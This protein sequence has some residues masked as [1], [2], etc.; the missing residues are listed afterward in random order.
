[1]PRIK[2]KAEKIAFAILGKPANLAAKKTERQ[3]EIDKI[4]SYQN[5][6]LIR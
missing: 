4:L 5:T 2:G 3:R 1:M 6:T